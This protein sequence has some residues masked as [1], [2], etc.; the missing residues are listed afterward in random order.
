MI[1]VCFGL[2][3]KTGRYS[4]FTGT[5]ILSIF[6]NTS[7]EVTVH[8]LHDD[9]LTTNHRENFIYLAGLYGQCIN[10][11]NVE[12]LCADKI[13]EM[14][15]LVPAIKN[16]RVS[17]GAFY[18]LLIP[19]LLPPDIEKS[20]YLDSDMLVNL[21]IKELWQTE[22]E[23]KPL[24][25]VREMDANA[26]NYEHFDAAQKYLLTESLV[27]YEDYFNSGVLVM[28]LRY[29]RRAEDFIMSGIK[30]RGEH[31][32][33]NCFDQD[34]WNYL[35]SKNYLRLPEKFDRFICNERSQDRIQIQ[36]AIYH[37]TSP[38]LGLDM[39]DPFNRL[40]MRYFMKTPWF[41]EQTLGRLYDNFQKNYFDLQATEKNSLISLSKIMSGKNRAFFVP[42]VYVDELKK[43][44]GVRDDEEIIIADEKES[45]PNLVYAM[46]KSQGKKIF[47]VLVSNFQA[48]SELLEQLDFVLGED[49]I[50]GLKFLPKPKS[51]QLNSYPL[52]Q[53]M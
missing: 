43:V 22:L 4:K 49:F 21:D 45:L 7:S 18:R 16:A 23:D 5:A 42:A 8:I 26:Y 25:A 15:R 33:C 14:V 48:I 47:F 3:D 37:C 6:A 52:I 50:N 44:F 28:N 9:T 39:S 24:A 2:H 53:A 51:S 41:S 12:E 31:P 32:Q 13:S 20:I 11:Y 40:W 19:Q 38:T 17:I 29:L 36:S 1:H 46:G 10:F 35:F 30:W 34:I 27:R